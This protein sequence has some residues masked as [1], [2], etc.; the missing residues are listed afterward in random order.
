MEVC[1]HV[2][3]PGRAARWRRGLGARLLDHLEAHARDHGVAILRLDTRDD[4]VEARR[5]YARHG[6]TEVRPLSQ[7]LYAG[8]WFEKHLPFGT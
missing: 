2:M 1:S 6:Y 3:L 8:H 4:L 7:G 5:L